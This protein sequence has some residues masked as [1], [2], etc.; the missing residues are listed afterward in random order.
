MII[1]A[2]G[3]NHTVNIEKK[4]KPVYTRAL[5]FVTTLNGKTQVSDRGE[6]AD[7]YDCT[8]TVIGDTAGINTLVSNLWLEKGQITI[9]TDG[10]K[11]FGTGIDHSGIFTCNILS[12]PIAYPVRDL[13][14]S[15]VKL[16]VRVVSAIVYNTSITAVL[17]TLFYQW[18]IGR[19]IN[20]QKI[21]YDSI[22][23]GDY[24]VNVRVDGAGN[25]IKSEIAKIKLKQ[26]DDEFGQLHRAV[27]LTR[28]ATFE[29]DTSVCLELFLGSTSTNVKILDFKYSPNGLK[30][31]DVSIT[32]ANNV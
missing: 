29:L 26:T 21:P 30:F 9:D 16:R 13:L 28:G 23:F 20:V 31:W 8:F 1:N 14:T 27:A 11:I 32:L 3:T 4:F 15:T 6:D 5:K 2:N 25:P 19:D 17:P 18:P 22:S 24:G 12:K 7:K 10:A